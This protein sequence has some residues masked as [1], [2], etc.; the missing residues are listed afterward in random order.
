IFPAIKYNQPT[1]KLPYSE[2]CTFSAQ[3]RYFDYD[4]FKKQ[5]YKVHRPHLKSGYISKVRYEGATDG[6]GNRD[7]LMCYTPGPKARAEFAAAHRGHKNAL[8][9]VQSIEAGE[10]QSRRRSAPRQ[11]RL[12]FES[13]R[14]TIQITMSTMTPP[15]S[16]I[17]SELLSA[18]TTRGI[19]ETTA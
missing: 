16:A 11:R 7:W 4:H 19:I 2:Y 13:P 3:Q 18:L 9:D 6:E 12:K 8:I 14:Q 10:R 17:N 15:E 1:A 5:M